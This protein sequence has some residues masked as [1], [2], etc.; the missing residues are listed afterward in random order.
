M[1]EKFKLFDDTYGKLITYACRLLFA[2]SLY[3]GS[4]YLN[5]NYVSKAYYDKTISAALV[6]KREAGSEQKSAFAQV[7]GKLDAI[8]LNN[9]ANDQKL[10]DLERRVGKVEDKVD[11]LKGN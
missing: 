7:N 1:L 2:I 9:A 8:L 5:T 6:E 11:R 10:L 3:A 4:A